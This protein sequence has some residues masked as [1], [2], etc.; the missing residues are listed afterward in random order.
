MAPP[1]HSDFC[2]TIAMTPPTA[3]SSALASAPTNAA[4]LAAPPA[5]A[6]RRG[7]QHLPTHRHWS[8][9]PPMIGAIADVI[10]IILYS[11][12]ILVEHP[13]EKWRLVYRLGRLLTLNEDPLGAVAGS[14]ASFM[15]WMPIAPQVLA[16]TC[17][18]IGI[19]SVKLA[20]APGAASSGS[21]L[22]VKRRPSR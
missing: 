8:I 20:T 18:A 19:Q 11:V 22:S 4:A 12:W 16:N 10:A 2:S 13:E 7:Y 17:A 15:D 6:H 14:V 21:S 1:S 9:Q 3:P 5:P